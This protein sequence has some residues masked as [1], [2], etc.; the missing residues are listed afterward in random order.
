MTN[1]IKEYHPNG[2]IKY[3]LIFRSIGNKCYEQY[4]DEVG[5][6]HN[7]NGPDY[8]SWYKN[9]Y[10]S[11]KIFSIHGVRH[12]IYNPSDIGFHLNGIVAYKS[13]YLNS[14]PRKNLSKLNW[15]CIIKNI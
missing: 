6:D 15:M 10:L 7:E 12:N 2:C 11:H 13:Y 9:G 4:L 3:K 14:I 5:N 8:Q 1:D